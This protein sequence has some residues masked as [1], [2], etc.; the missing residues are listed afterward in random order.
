MHPPIEIWIL[1]GILLIPLL[2]IG[3]R[4]IRREIDEYN[5]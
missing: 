5:E 2:I 1:G 3:L 4:K